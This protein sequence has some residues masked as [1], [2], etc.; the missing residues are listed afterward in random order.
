MAKRQ[1]PERHTRMVGPRRSTNIGRIIGLELEQQRHATLQAADSDLGSNQRRSH[2]NSDDSPQRDLRV[3]GF[4]SNVAGKLYQAQGLLPRMDYLQFIQTHCQNSHPPQHWFWDLRRSLPVQVCELQHPRECEIQIKGKS[5]SQTPRRRGKVPLYLPV[6]AGDRLR[7][8]VWGLQIWEP[9]WNRGIGN[10]GGNREMATPIHEQ[11]KRTHNEG[12]REQ[13]T[14]DQHTL[15][16]T[17]V[18]LLRQTPAHLRTLC[19]QGI[20]CLYKVNTKKLTP[21]YADMKYKPM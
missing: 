2:E 10:A 4:H 20:L 1:I 7:K 3:Q 17:I 16:I 18:S 5:K 8:G 19:R 11:H 14:N 13:F 12:S 15:S 9:R 21:R 6:Q